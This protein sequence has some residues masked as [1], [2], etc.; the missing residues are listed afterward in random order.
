V[1]RYLITGDAGFI[2]FHLSAALLREGHE[3][4][5]IDG[6]TEYYDPQL[7]ADRLDILSRASGFTHFTCMLERIES[8][9][10]PITQ[11]A[12]EI[13][14]HLAAQ[15]GVRYSLENPDA[16]LSSNIDGTL[17][18]LEL[19]RDLRPRHF[20]L[21]STSSVYGGNQSIPFAE[22]D[23]TRAPMSLYAATKIAAEALT[24]SF[25]HLWGIP[26][27]VFR[28]FTVYGPWGRPDMALFKF[29]DALRSG[30]PIDIYGHGEMQRDFTYVGDLVAAVAALAEVAPRIGSRVSEVDTLSPVAPYRIVNIGGGKPVPLMDFVEAIESSVGVTAEKNFL[31][32]QPGDVVA[33]S[34]DP[35]LLRQLIGSAPATSVRE[36]VSAFADWHLQYFGSRDA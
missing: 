5:G 18:M 2:G 28:F 19:A 33:T 36:G 35:T 11:F 7:K 29:V 3:V 9:R 4:L 15:A 8:L 16:Y 13:I 12:P 21:A 27:T 30:K 14:I 26:S 32:M 23:T 17:R 10:A 22:L 1:T 24:H 20:L 31:P 34:A 6:L 25:S